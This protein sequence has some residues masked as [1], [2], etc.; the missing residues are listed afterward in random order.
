MKRKNYFKPW[1]FGI[2]AG[3]VF[4]GAELVFSIYPPS[5]YAFCL[6]CHTRDMLN[7]IINFAA[8]TRFESSYAGARVFFVT[9]PALLLGA[10]FAAR[11]H[12]E[13]T[14]LKADRPLRFFFFG[15]I[16]MIIGI[17]IFGCPTRLILRS[18]YGDVYAIGAVLAMAFGIW[19]GTMILKRRSGM[20]SVP[21]GGNRS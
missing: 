6:T 20:P 17:V 15:F 1:M 16:I 4:V 12:K 10:F 2:A 11:I 7:R 18:G 9:S 5:A 14:P 8:G 21:A 13:R 3:A 19:A